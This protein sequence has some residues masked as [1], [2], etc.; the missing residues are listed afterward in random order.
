MTYSIVAFDPA[1]GEL[2]AAVQSRWFG[3]GQ[4]RPVGRAGRRR[5]R[6]P[7]VHRDGPRPERA[8]ADAR[9][10]HGHRGAGRG[11]VVRSGRGRAPGGHGRRE[12]RRGRAHRLAL[13]PLRLAS[14]RRR[15]GRAGEH[16]GALDGPGRDARGICAA[17]T[18]TSRRG[19]WRRC[20][21]PRR[22]GGDVRGRQSAALVV[23]PGPVRTGRRRSRGRGASTCGS[24]TTGRRSTSWPGSCRWR[25]PTRR[26]TR[27]RRRA[28][29]ATWPPPRR[30]ANA[31]GP[32]APD[33]DQILLWHAVG[34]GAGGTPGR[35]ARR[36]GRGRTA[37]EPRAGEHLR[38]FAEQ[39]HLPGGDAVLRALGL[40]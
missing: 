15:R 28:A 25:A 40:L 22:E 18:A 34:A 16:D 21:P 24:R 2:G 27:P 37:V 5:R 3:V 10:P 4:R 11:P 35:G 7:V 29:A 26:W 36:A 30:R 39:D 9:G 33:D 23:A 32:W 17:R 12:R 8:A 19:C 31:R 6:D 13:R 20:S 1:T 14:R 38:R